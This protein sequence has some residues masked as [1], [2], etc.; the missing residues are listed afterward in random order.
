MMGLDNQSHQLCLTK[1]V[2]D[3]K[4]FHHLIR[5]LQMYHSIMKN[6]FSF[7]T[8]S[9]VLFWWNFHHRLLSFWQFLVQPMME[10]SSEWRHSC[11]SDWKLN[12]WSREKN[13]CIWCDQ[14]WQG[15]IAG[16]IVMHQSHF[17][18]IDLFHQVAMWKDLLLSTGNHDLILRLMLLGSTWM[19]YYSYFVC[20]SYFSWYWNT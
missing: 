20:I 14:L 12:R 3:W 2:E 19:I 9:K 17:R 8:E 11:F 4:R 13:P 1:C 10:I 5:S 16:P 7:A 18:V 6:L 15:T